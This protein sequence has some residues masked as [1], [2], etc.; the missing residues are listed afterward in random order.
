M[1]GNRS[2]FVCRSFPS[3]SRKHFVFTF[4]SSSLLAFHSRLGV[5]TFSFYI[6]MW[7]HTSEESHRVEAV[8]SRISPRLAYFSSDED[9][10]KG[11]R[12]DG[13][14]LHSMF[15]AHEHR[16]AIASQP[17][18]NN[19]KQIKSHNKPFCAGSKED[20]CER[21]SC[22][23]KIDAKRKISDTFLRRIQS[24]DFQR[25]W[26]TRIFSIRHSKEL[27]TQLKDLK[28]ER[29]LEILSKSKDN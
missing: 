19:W 22:S 1:M 25:C 2:R 7:K 23:G 26:S 16:R 13:K 18:W 3:S 10:W 17:L 14:G 6:S 24:R 27:K 21:N 28:L 4:L 15:Y 11:I 29:S 8:E 9:S 12:W 20:F 5:K